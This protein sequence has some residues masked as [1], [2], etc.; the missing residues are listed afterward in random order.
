[1]TEKVIPKLYNKNSS[2]RH[3][4]NAQ[5]LLAL[6][7]KM[8]K[9]SGKFAY[10][11]ARLFFL[12]DVRPYFFLSYAYFRWVDDFADSA[13]S[14]IEAK[15]LFLD[16]QTKLVQELYEGLHPT[17]KEVGEQFLSLLISFD[18]SRGSKLR[19]PFLS[20][21]S[22]INYDVRRAGEP[23]SQEMLNHYID[24]E[25]ESSMK[26]FI[27]F[28]YPNVNLNNFTKSYEGIAAKWSHILRDFVSDVQ[29]GMI[30]ISKQEMAKFNVDLRDLDSA[31]F[32]K[33]VEN[34]VSDAEKNFGLARKNLHQ[35]RY[36]RYKIA[37]A[38][39]C[40]KYEYYPY[41]IK[42]DLFKLREQYERCM[43]ENCIFFIRLL[44]D[45]QV[46]LVVHFLISF[47]LK[48]KP[49]FRILCSKDS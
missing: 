34:K 2:I 1:M 35:H 45:I 20:L 28:C 23:P 48:P 5:D 18:R 15:Q 21:L 24:L 44:K 42:K 37:V 16:Q 36:L 19:M 49:T 27:Y 8:T 47:G 29:E 41:H 30:N 31:N 17:C 25:V 26:T 32:R 33:W 43:F 3:F 13:G 39:L 6:A 7:E 40:A 14:S 12:S 22:C 38:V 10:M 46:I 11:M 4:Y 9:K